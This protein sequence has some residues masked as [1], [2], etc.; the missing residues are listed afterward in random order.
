MNGG[1]PEFSNR[2]PRYLDAQPKIFLW[3]ADEFVVAVAPVG[4]GI[5]TG[6]ILTSIV[7]GVLMAYGL[8]K[9]K[10][11]QG[12]GFMMRAAYWYLPGGGI[13]K[14]KRTPPSHVREYVG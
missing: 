6:F 10:K 2:I 7:L 13:A 12:S 8:A 11:G 3:D 14:L 9:L 5:V 1:G 4:V